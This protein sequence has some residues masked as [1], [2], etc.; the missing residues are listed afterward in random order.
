MRPLTTLLILAAC[1]SSFGSQGV[2]G[3][4]GFAAGGPYAMPVGPH[5]L[6]VESQQPPR[7]VGPF[8]HSVTET[9]ANIEWWASEA[10]GYALQWE[11]GGEEAG[12]AVRYGHKAVSFSLTGLAPGVEYRLVIEPDKP[13]ARAIEDGVWSE[14]VQSIAIAFA[15][16]EEAYEPRVYYVATDGDDT[17]SGL[18]RED[19]WRTVIHAADRARPGD[20]VIVGGGAYAE[21]VR[22]RATGEESRPITF[23]AALGEKVVFDGLARTLDHAFYA[24]DKHHLRFD[25]FYFVGFSHGSDS[26]PW[27]LTNARRNNGSVMLYHCNDVRITRCFHDGRGPG[28]SPGLA[29]A[30]HCADF[31]VRNCVVIASMGGGLGIW[32]DSPRARVENNVF[33]RNLISHAGLHVWRH[34]VREPEDHCHLDRNIFTDNLQSKLHVPLL[35]IAD[36]ALARENCFYLRVPADERVWG[37]GGMDTVADF[38]EHSAQEWPGRENIAAVPMFRATMDMERADE[39]GVPRYLGD[40]LISLRELDFPDLFATNPDLVE[41]G[42]GLQPEA[43]EDF[44]FNVAE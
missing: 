9:T 32:W 16:A 22:I 27:T 38:L 24:A 1:L 36:T 44:H 5:S 23:K 31:R 15:T 4:G 39:D 11:R 29:F 41:R 12:S 26:A 18:S 8:V 3:D 10:L 2:A 40:A 25:G 19:A 17:R 37:R 14:A 30:L 43:F 21:S 35:G 42:I 28:Y 6:A 13:V 33:L 34:R 20:T 7:F